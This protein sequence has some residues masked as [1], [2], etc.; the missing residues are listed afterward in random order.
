MKIDHA[1]RYECD[2]ADTDRVCIDDLADGDVNNRLCHSDQVGVLIHIK[3][4]L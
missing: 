3:F 1:S 2:F 4:I